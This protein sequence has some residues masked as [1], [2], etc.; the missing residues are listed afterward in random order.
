MYDLNPKQLVCKFAI[1]FLRELFY[2][3]M[4]I[5]QK[6]EIHLSVARLLQ[7][8]KFSY[9]PHNKEI[10]M[11]QKHLKITEKSI[12]NYMEEDDDNLQC[13]KVAIEP[14][15]LN[16]L[17]IF[18]VKDICG[19]LKAIDLRLEEDYELIKNNP[20]IKSGTVNKKS[21]KNITWEE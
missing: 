12:I 6:N 5:E 10:M 8:T 19:R 15:S 3:R 11:L 13:K 18:Q 20:K 16:N 14:L 1:P 4:L 2:Q 17:K 21:D 9:I 7:N